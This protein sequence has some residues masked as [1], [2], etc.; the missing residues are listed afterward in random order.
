MQSVG[1]KT[2]F[3]FVGDVNAHHREW[4]GSSMKNLHDRAARGFS[5]SSGCKQMTTELTHIDGGM[6]DLVLTDVSDIVGVRIG[7]PVGA[8]DHSVI[9]IEVVLEQ[10]IPHLIGV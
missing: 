1:G 9:F 10:P 5:S 4:L 3:L 6:L 7:S 8:S 2:S